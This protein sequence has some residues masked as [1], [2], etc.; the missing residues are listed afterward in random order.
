M[1]CVP[2]PIGMPHGGMLLENETAAERVPHASIATGQ[3]DPVANSGLES[4]ALGRGEGAER[5]ARK[6]NIERTQAGGIRE[7]VQ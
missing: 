1:E 4:L 2:E 6:D 5:P 3:P 7:N